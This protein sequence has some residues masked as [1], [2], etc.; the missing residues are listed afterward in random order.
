M[1]NIGLGIILVLTALA[2]GGCESEQDWR[3]RVMWEAQRQLPKGCVLYMPKIDNRTIYVVSCTQVPATSTSW[4]VPNGK[5]QTTMYSFT[6][7]SE[8]KS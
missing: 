6:I 7:G 5:T 2:L 4:N 8:S 1:K 3:D